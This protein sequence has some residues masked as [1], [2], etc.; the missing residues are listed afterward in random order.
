[1][2]QIR[3]LCFFLILSNSV[4]SQSMQGLDASTFQLAVKLNPHAQLVDIRMSKAYTEGHIKG[5][6]S[7]VY[8]DAN[9]EEM[10]YTKIDK[11][12]PVYLYCQTGT[13]SKNAVIFL[14]E[15]GFEEVHYLDKGFTRWTSSSKPYVSLLK[16]TK[17]IASFTLDDLNRVLD[18]NQEVFLFLYAPGC[19]D[20]KVMEP[21][22]RR[23]TGMETPTKLLEI[24]M[25]KEKAIAEHFNASETPTMLLFRNGR[26]IWKYTG[27]ITEENL[28]VVLHKQSR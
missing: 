3:L 26:Q 23:N 20:C 28:Q 22:I 17:P 10:A 18:N 9:F 16:T 1:M 11:K 4:F 6:L 19:S 14:K 24:D 7:L 27:Q 15:L 2:I 12:R 25:S 8:E 21:I 13:E 5:A